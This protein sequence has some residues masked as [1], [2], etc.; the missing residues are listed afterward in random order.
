M[1]IEDFIL[2]IISVTSLITSIITSVVVYLQ[3]YKIN[4]YEFMSKERTKK[5]I[6]DL[7]SAL[8]LIMEK[9]MYGHLFDINYDEEKKILLN[10]LLSD[11]WMITR[12]IIGNDDNYTSIS[13]EFYYIIYSKDGFIGDKGRRKTLENIHKILNLIMNGMNYEEIVRKI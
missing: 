9:S 12:Q 5:D 1:K 2:I 6:L 10:F 4:E 3:T 11:T 7:L 13:A 8:N